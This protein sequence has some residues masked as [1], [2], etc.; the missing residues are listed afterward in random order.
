[1]PT[2]EYECTKCGKSFEAFQSMND[3]PLE[4]CQHCGAKPKRMN[5]KGSGIIFKG[6]GFY[7]TDY[8]RAS[9]PSPKPP[10]KSSGC[11]CCSLSHD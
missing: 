9:K 8:K 5:G 3:K 7:E 4:K 10:C 6:S 11:K 2:Y 1:M